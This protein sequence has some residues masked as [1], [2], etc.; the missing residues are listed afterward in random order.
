M[1]RLIQIGVAVVALTLLT[2]TW[3]VQG[4]V[5]PLV[6]AGGSMAPALLGAHRR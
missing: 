3:L 4:L 2:R 5:D 1:R 6:V